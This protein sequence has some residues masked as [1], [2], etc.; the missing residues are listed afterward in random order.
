MSSNEEMA[1]KLMGL[2]EG[3]TSTGKPVKDIRTA[4][5]RELT[6]DSSNDI[7][8]EYFRLLRQG[9]L[10]KSAVL[11]CINKDGLEENKKNEEKKIIENITDILQEQMQTP[12]PNIMSDG[13]FRKYSFYDTSEATLEN[14]EQVKNTV[15]E[16]TMLNK[17][18][19][20]EDK[21]SEALGFIATVDRKLWE[22]EDGILEIELPP[23]EET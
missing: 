18:N 6:D 11:V 13:S 17:I 9:K 1:K 8:K 15:V 23:D 7:K 12:R 21:Y 10:I 3:K 14:Y 2:L 22:Y 4:I 5:L 20:M 16:N 19:R